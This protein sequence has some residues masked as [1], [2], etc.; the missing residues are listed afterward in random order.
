MSDYTVVRAF[1]DRFTDRRERWIATEVRDVLA[2]LD[3]MQAHIETLPTQATVSDALARAERA[4]AALAA[5]QR[6]FT[7]FEM[8]HEDERDQL[9]A[10]A[11]RAEAALRAILNT[12]AAVGPDSPWA[13]AERA[14]YPQ[15]TESE[16]A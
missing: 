9:L 10:R 6:D 5:S 8:L 15:P 13:I 4:E 2:A 1:V 12:E 16:E 11:E 3:R 14:V 7:D